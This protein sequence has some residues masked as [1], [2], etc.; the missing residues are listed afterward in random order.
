[1]AFLKIKYRK[2]IYVKVFCRLLK[3]FE[4]AFQIMGHR[5]GE[6]GNTE[7]QSSIL[8]IASQNCW[9]KWFP[10]GL[11]HISCLINSFMAQ[12]MRS[13]TRTLR[14][15]CITMRRTEALI[16][17]SYLISPLAMLYSASQI[18]K[19]LFTCEKI[20]CSTFLLL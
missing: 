11:S 12:R 4:V 18:T 9:F 7:T 16:L 3:C 17:E 20:Q 10:I 6:S 15:F 8:Y 1:L 2:I 13:G 19:K 5:F 14:Q